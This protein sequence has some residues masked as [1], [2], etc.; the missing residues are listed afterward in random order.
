LTVGEFPLQ[1]VDLS[2]FAGRE[3]E[4]VFRSDPAG[5][6]HYDYVFLG[7]PAVASRKQAPRRVLMV[8]V[9]TLRPD[10]LGVYGYARPTSPKLDAWAEQATVFEQARTVAPWTLPSAQTAITGRHPEYYPSTP[11]LPARLRERGF[12]TAM[13]AG[14]VYLSANFGMTRDWGLHRVGMWPMAEDVTDDA[15]AWLEA[16]EGRDALLLVHYMDP[17]LP[18]KEP[19]SY[20][21]LFAG[22]GCCG[23]REEFHLSDVKRAQVDT[24]EE[25]QYILDRYDNNV[26]YATDQVARLLE[27]VDE[28]DVVVFY[29]DHGEEFWEHKGFEHGH[30]LFDELLRIPLIVKGPGLPAGARV[31][32]PVSLLDIV[33]TVLD[34]LKLPAPAAPLDGLSLVPAARGDSPARLALSGRDLAFGR[35]LYGT[36]RWGV[37]HGTDKWT[38]NEGREA[39]YHLD[40]DPGEADNVLRNDQAAAGAQFRD[41][42]ARGL[43]RPVPVS[44]RLAAT[45]WTAKGTP[46]H[47]LVVTLRA[48]G[49]FQAAWVGDD[50]LDNSSATAKILEDGSAEVRW[51]AGHKFGREV[52]VLPNGPVGEVTHAMTITVQ[53]GSIEKTFQ[54]PASQP[55]QPGSTR[56]PLARAKTEHR[57]VGITWG[58][59]PQRTR[60]MAELM[61]RDAELN[62]MLE[63]MGYTDPRDEAAP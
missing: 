26:R 20:R 38:T 18:Y 6:A 30:T 27:A 39:L 3:V 61:G 1:R 60:E 22:D 13:F 62:T 2:A 52:Y 12:A 40:E 21:H 31:K 49:G 35:P 19:K 56:L 46:P 63:S 17:H 57:G 51:L 14:N 50:P 48:P 7:E 53:E 33:P 10:H 42:L 16:H 29:A 15:L 24:P 9:D 44:Y 25:R 59:A 11:T 32:E 54:I 34:L 23:L 5:D 45:A 41:Y 55:A 47:D 43:G 37:L 58:L 8:F 4:V 36:E 28:Q